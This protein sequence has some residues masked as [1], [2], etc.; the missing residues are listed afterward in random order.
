MLLSTSCAAA[1]KPL[2][3]D[4]Q[5]DDGAKPSTTDQTTAAADPMTQDTPAADGQQ[6]HFELASRS[7]NDDCDD[8][9]DVEEPK[10]MEQYA[11]WHELTTATHQTINYA[12]Y[13]LRYHNSNAFP[14]YLSKE[15]SDQAD[16][17][18]VVSTRGQTLTRRAQHI[19]QVLGADED[20][21]LEGVVTLDQLPADGQSY[22]LRY[23][24]EATCSSRNPHTLSLGAVIAIQGGSQVDVGDPRGAL[25]HILMAPCCPGP[26]HGR[27]PLAASVGLHWAPPPPNPPPATM[28]P[29]V[30]LTAI[31]STSK[32]HSNTSHTGAD[33]WALVPTVPA[34]QPNPIGPAQMLESN[35]QAVTD[36]NYYFTGPDGCLYVRVD[37]ANIPGSS[38]TPLHINS[39]L[40]GVYTSNSAAGSTKVEIDDLHLCVTYK[41][42]A[43]TG[44]VAGPTVEWKACPTYTPPTPAP[45]SCWQVHGLP[46]P[47]GPVTGG[48]NY[49]I[50]GDVTFVSPAS[51]PAARL[52]TCEVNALGYPIPN[53]GTPVAL[54]VVP[55]SYQFR[56]LQPGFY[57]VEILDGGTVVPGPPPLWNPSKPITL[58]GPSHTETIDF[59]FP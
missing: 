24:P 30:P 1:P 16:V 15:R 57:Q 58:S 39:P 29:A 11:S 35:P 43:T 53:A 42:D 10:V 23:K 36:G 22:E 12:R 27:Q 59:A 50:K 6:L 34:I 49:E 20:T 54:S 40:V 18:L 13:R 51:A 8:T 32:C 2:D 38:T 21:W 37:V 41:A 45:N 5:G 7:G 26:G 19:E 44:V 46:T 33:R 52:L 3:D 31:L 25:G 48:G 4:K 47:S 56:D 55:P 9:A 28:T 14:L 17:I